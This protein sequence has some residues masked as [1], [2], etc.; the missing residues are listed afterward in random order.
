MKTPCIRLL[1]AA[2]ILSSCTVGPN[3]TP[4]KNPSARNW[5]QGNSEKSAT[6]PDTWWRLFDDAELNRLID[7]A[8]ASNN[9][10]AA[11]KSRV[12][13][14]RALVGADRA[15]LFPTLD[16]L[17]SPGIARQSQ[18]SL[19]ANLPPGVSIPLE[20]QRYRGT[21]DLAYDLD[22]WGRNKRAVEASS[23]RSS[24]QE[25]LLDAQRLGIAAEVARQYFLLRG[26]D[27]QHAVLLN[28]RKSREESLSLQRSKTTAGLANGIEVKRAQTQLEL[29]ANDI[30]NIERQ[31]G[32]T[33]HALAV[34]C[35]RAPN[36]FHIQQK[37]AKRTLPIIR[38]GLPAEV[39]C[40]RPDVR[41]ALQQ[42]RAANADIGIAETAFYPNFTLKTTAGFESLDLTKFLDLQNRIL[43]LGANI[44]TPILNGGAHKANYQAARSRYEEALA[45][46]QQTLLIALREVEDSLVDL[47]GLTKSSTALEQAYSSSQE[48]LKL[49]HERHQK[50]LTSYF[51]VFDAEREAL[52]IQLALAE[53]QAQQRISLTTLAQ[54][55]GG[56]WA[57][58]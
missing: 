42:L 5:K 31:R 24:A 22:L 56:G 15:K 21:F 14:A 43:S 1:T 39:L 29:L 11:A 55:L 28:T 53:V 34:L 41:A 51:E 18:D 4:P 26:L 47:K 8:L 16:L 25:A 50:G 49:T 30:A 9:D 46:Y 12:N 7:Q 52:Q 40:R 38:P 3:F 10:I 19:G 33:E 23:S 48:T 45:Q 6:L 35:G 37:V 36:L 17:A 20:Q 44:A 57:G 32:S 58:K 2:L 54:A 27:E 13:T